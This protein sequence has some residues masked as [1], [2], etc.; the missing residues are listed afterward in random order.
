LTIYALTSSLG[1]SIG[2]TPQQFRSA[3][4]GKTAASATLN[5]KYTP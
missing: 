3:V 5:G 1:I 4:A 2:A